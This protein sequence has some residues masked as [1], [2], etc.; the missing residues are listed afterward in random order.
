MANVRFDHFAIAVSRWEETSAFYRD[1]LGA[2]VVEHTPGHHAFR[3]AGNQ[4]NVVGPS[5]FAHPRE[6]IVA[7]SADM[8]FVWP[9]PVEEAQSYLETRGVEII[10]GP[11]SRPGAGGPGMSVYFRDPEGNLLEFI[12]YP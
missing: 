2:E 1:L 5:P 10:A 11:M 8:C 4:I 7:G 6:E 3:W 12:S 9:G